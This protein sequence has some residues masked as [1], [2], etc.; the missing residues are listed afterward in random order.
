MKVS[1]IT[2]ENV[3]AFCRIDDPDE[4]DR[5]Q[6]DIAMSAARAFIRSYTGLDDESIDEHE[7]FCW[8]FLIL[9]RDNYDN[10]S[11]AESGS[12][13]INRTVG[14]IL[15]MHSKNLLG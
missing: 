14:I 5:S 13:K 9:C 1:E 6:V 4:D 7:D 3:I 12:M 8:A 10:R 11:L 15:D 2:A